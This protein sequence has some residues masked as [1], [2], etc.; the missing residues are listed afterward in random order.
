M[1]QA[2]SMV[3]VVNLSSPV[4]QHHH[5]STYS[6]TGSRM[7]LFYLFFSFLF[8]RPSLRDRWSGQFRSHNRIFGTILAVT[9]VAG[10]PRG[11]ASECLKC[12]HLFLNTFQLFD[13][14]WRLSFA[15]I[16]ECFVRIHSS[17]LGVPVEWWA[18]LPIEGSV[19]FIFSRLM[20]IVI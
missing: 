9:S 15:F 18:F 13:L 4:T 2:S 11:D 19:R 16:E 17:R 5:R 14:I 8:R 20:I 1:M 6:M 10:T 3:R 7:F 12:V